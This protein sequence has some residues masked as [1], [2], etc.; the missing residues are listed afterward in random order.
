MEPLSGVLA[1]LGVFGIIGAVLLGALLLV[2]I[3]IWAIFDCA[4]SSRDSGTKA[5]V[6][7]LIVLSWTVGSLVY[8]IFFAS[9]RALRRFTIVSLVAMSLLVVASVVFLL[10]G[11]SMHDQA[12]QERRAA[13]EAQVRAAFTPERVDPGA[14]EPFKAIHFVYHGGSSTSTAA[15]DFTLA[16]P[17]RNTALNIDERI[18]HIVFEPRNDRYYGLTQHEFGI[19][20]PGERT[21]EEIA[22]DPA[23]EQDFSWPKGLAIDPAS[24]EFII[25]TSH[26]DTDLFVY[27]PESRAWKKIPTGIRG[28][29]FIALA[30]SPEDQ[31]FY[32]LED[33]DGPAISSL[34]RFNRSGADLGPLKINPAIP[35]G[36]NHGEHSQMTYR[37]GR[38]V[39]IIPPDPAAKD[40]ATEATIFAI[41]PRDGRVS[42]AAAG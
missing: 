6:I 32:L 30:Y 29:S 7:I 37:S 41:D 1:G 8:S 25:L 2:L 23:L 28:R 12:E 10:S 20:H 14:I 35:V 22:P 15:A 19:V 26:V 5:L 21:F 31:I 13:E 39:L 17:L 18:R 24:G 38:I 34:Q 16:G 27:G 33:S 40:G 42:T 9:S 3:P 4:Y 36:R 11:A